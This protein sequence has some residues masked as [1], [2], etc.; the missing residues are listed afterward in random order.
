MPDAEREELCGASGELGR[1]LA[2]RRV[3][4]KTL[5]YA[6]QMVGQ[7]ILWLGLD[8]QSIVAR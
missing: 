4:F 1:N 2:V 8:E 5:L 6:V 3:A 7:V